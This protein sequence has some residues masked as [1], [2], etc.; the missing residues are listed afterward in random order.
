VT[1]LISASV[2]RHR[3]AST[4]LVFGD[5]RGSST[6]RAGLNL[7]TP[8]RDGLSVRQD[9]LDFNIGYLP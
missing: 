5:D 9:F 4:A 1:S 2:P 6:S 7:S 8:L 3:R